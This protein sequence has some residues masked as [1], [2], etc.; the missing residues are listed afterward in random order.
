MGTYKHVF[1]CKHAFAFAS[2]HRG[3]NSISCLSW[4]Q[5]SAS[6]SPTACFQAA[7]VVQGGWVPGG[8]AR[9]PSVAPRWQTVRGDHRAAALAAPQVRRPLAWYCYIGFQI[10]I[11]YACYAAVLRC[12]ACCLLSCYCSFMLM[13]FTLLRRCCVAAAL[14]ACACL[15]VAGLLFCCLLVGLVACFLLQY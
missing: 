13:I 8:T 14:L 7:P 5:A 4:S 15:L 11:F 1:A 3:C 2:A 12:A 10:Y 9:H 6:S